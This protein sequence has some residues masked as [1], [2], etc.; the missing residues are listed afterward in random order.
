MV[1]FKCPVCHEDVKM[2]EHRNVSRVDALFWHI[3][4]DHLSGLA[5][6]PPGIGPPLPQAVGLRW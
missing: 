1:T 2:P 4:E 6:T 5:P 3:A